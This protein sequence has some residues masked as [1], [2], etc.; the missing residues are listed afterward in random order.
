[1]KV[2]GCLLMPKNSHHVQLREAYVIDDAIENIISNIKENISHIN[3]AKIL[4]TGASGF[5]GFWFLRLFIQ[6]HNLNLFH[7]ELILVTRNKKNILHYIPI[8]SE[9]KWIH[10]IEGD[11]RSVQFKN[12]NPDHLIHFASTSAS[13]TYSGIEQI[14]KIDTLYLG[15]KNI[16][17]Q[18]G[19]TLKK[20]VFASSGAAY[21]FIDGGKN[22]TEE[23]YSMLQ[24]QDEKYALCIGKIVSE[25][26]IK[27][28]SKKFGFDY[29]IARCFSFAGEFMPLNFHYAVGNFI[30]NALKS[31][32]IKVHGDGSTIRS[33]MYVGDAITWLMTLLAEPKNEV[34]NVGSDEM[35]TI[36]EVAEIVARYADTTVEIL[37]QVTREGNFNRSAYVPD[38]TKIRHLYP[39]LQLNVTLP[40]IVKRM[41]VE[42]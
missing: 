13:E 34:L 36:R 19:E 37:G 12:F 3:A 7:G 14:E 42:G 9:L 40:M 38:L 22:I 28:Y 11:I 24:S 16:F 29:S 26:Q 1:M 39:A 25:F 35:Y 2:S 33:Y 31:E 20:V 32:K 27:Q 18:C 15:T 21:G 41:L 23:N 30:E 4:F 10:I 17:E 6:L 8:I 5:F